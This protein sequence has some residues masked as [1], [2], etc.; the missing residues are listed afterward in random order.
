MQPT[1]P[2]SRYKNTPRYLF[3]LDEN[4]TIGSMVG[5]PR[6]TLGAIVGSA[7]HTIVR[8]ETFQDIATRYYNA[9][10]HWDVIASANTNIFYPGDI[11][12]FVGATI[13]I[14]PPSYVQG[15]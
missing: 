2:P 1:R 7:R 13:I 5:F 10:E 15:L 9:P 3:A 4:V 8:G 14:P 11:V 6:T 12:N